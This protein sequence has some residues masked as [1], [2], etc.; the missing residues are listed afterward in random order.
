MFAVLVK[1][2][3]GKINIKNFTLKSI[4][5]LDE[6]KNNSLKPILKSLIC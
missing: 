4:K 5:L 3:D 6:A 1:S 2:L